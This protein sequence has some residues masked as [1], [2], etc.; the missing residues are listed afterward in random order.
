MR[1]M[2]KCGRRLFQLTGV[3]DEGF[4]GVGHDLPSDH[5]LHLVKGGNCTPQIFNPS[6]SSERSKLL[7]REDAESVRPGHAEMFDQRR[8]VVCQARPDA[9][10]ALAYGTAT[11]RTRH[12]S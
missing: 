1:P 11:L 2:P 5:G 6:L 4:R 9:S 7:F 12:L 10:A 3:V 8:I